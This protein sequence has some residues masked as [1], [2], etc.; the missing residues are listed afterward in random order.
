[1]F[2]W[3]LSI[4]ILIVATFIG[5]NPAGADDEY[6]RLAREIEQY[7]EQGYPERLIE[8]AFR[9]DA[10]IM[11]SDRDPLDVIL[12]RTQA[13]A[14][15]LTGMTG[16]PD[17]SSEQ[18]ALEALHKS[19]R[20]L[21]SEEKR[22]ALF[23]KVV[24]LRRRIA[25][26]NPLL[27]F[28][29]IV[30]LTHHR[31]ARGAIH[32]V[33]QYEGHTA[34]AGGGVYIL[35]NAFSDAP[36]V[37]NVLEGRHVTKGKRAGEALLNG[38]FISLDLD[39][40]AQTIAFA[41]TAAMPAP[42]DPKL[43]EGQYWSLEEARAEKLPG[44]Y[45]H[46]NTSYHVFTANIDGSALTQLTDGIHNDFDPCFLPNGRIV[47]VS[48]RR[49]GYLRCGSRPNPTYTLFGMMA[50][51][52]DI[53]PLSYHETH[54]WHPSVNNDGMIVYTRWDY[55][56]RD[57]DIAHHIW[58]TYPD[59]CDPRSQHGNYPERREMR[60]WMELA[61][62]AIPDSHKY[63]ATAAPHHGENYGSL[64]IIDQRDQDD[65]A[66]NQLKRLT[67][68]AHFP[69]SEQR[70]G[71][72]HSKG[73]HN[74]RGE[75]YGQAWPLS[76]N[77]YLCVYD[78]AQKHYGIYL[79]DSF[80][81]KILLYND[82]DVACLDPIPLKPRKRPSVIPSRTTQALA[83]RG[84]NDRDTATVAI[85]NVYDAELPWPDNTTI[86]AIR[87]IQLFPK[88]TRKA[89]EPMMGAAAQS[90]GRGVLGTAPVEQDG[91]A[92]FEI[93][94]G[95]PVYFQALDA[96]GR[97]VQTMRSDTYAHRGEQL[98]CIGCHESK[99][100]TTPSADKQ[101]TLALQRSPSKLKK[102]LEGSWPLTFSKLVQPVLDKHC[103]ACHKKEE[104]APRLSD[105]TGKYGWSEAYHALAPHTWGKHGGNGALI[106]VNKTSYSIPGQI[107]AYGAPL[108]KHLEKGHHNVKLSDKEWHA[109]TLWLDCNSN[110]YGVYHDLIQQAKG[111]I[112]LPIIE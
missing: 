24:Q 47:F 33:D 107:G 42:E 71:V 2:S 60:P 88:T 45:W 112:V 67:P 87:V 96:K 79:L 73:T 22:S 98:T 97:A 50:D 103:T 28:D 69:E 92:Y 59:G 15:H 68:E 12:R 29:D 23:D 110:F 8:E 58:L 84:D 54:E 93:P 25:F 13:L 17:L 91:S 89:G 86:E 32:M 72:L 49:G 75:V 36:T 101:S 66:T 76:E 53:I 19:A 43:W 26:K 109:I 105:K 18:K 90:L 56:D 55:V 46:E 78:P 82:P 94:V 108:L 99:Y 81:N 20:K 102:D 31:Q 9:R 52:S 40:D 41:W 106:T 62:R 30:F 95:I 3:K 51:G 70:P 77:F 16:A 14:S 74:P 44:Y 38:S 27:D 64:V 10:L 80:G 6:Q 104:K 34:K 83:D 65:K 48:E 37:T 4:S 63:V 85:M 21:R 100:R 1:M 35:H 11:D 7:Q 57:S 111:E 61:I 39:Y 5:V